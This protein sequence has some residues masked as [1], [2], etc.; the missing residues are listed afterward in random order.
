MT[1]PLEEG[2]AV[3]VVVPVTSESSTGTYRAHCWSSTEVTTLALAHNR[4]LQR[5]PYRR[6][7]KVLS[8]WLFLHLHTEYTRGRDILPV[9]ALFSKVNELLR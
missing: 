5:P 4:L 6:R 2:E 3:T 1:F 9:S 8:S 7:L